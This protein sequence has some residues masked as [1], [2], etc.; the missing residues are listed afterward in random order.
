MIHDTNIHHIIIILLS[1]L[2]SYRN[3]I[4]KSLIYFVIICVIIEWVREDNVDSDKAFCRCKSGFSR[5]LSSR[6]NFSPALSMWRSFPGRLR[7]LRKQTG[8]QTSMAGLRN[9]K[10]EREKGETEK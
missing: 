9:K 8:E 3:F 2:S 6:V 1:L 10:G 7:V 5:D 4:S